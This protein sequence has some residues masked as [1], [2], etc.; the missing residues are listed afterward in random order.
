MLEGRQAADVL[1]M[2]LSTNPNEKDER[3]H[4]GARVEDGLGGSAMQVQTCE[5]ADML[6][7]ARGRI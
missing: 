4:T 7:E 6:D 2:D 1:A 5:M 3:C